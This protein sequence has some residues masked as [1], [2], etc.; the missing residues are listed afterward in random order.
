MKAAEELDEPMP[1][2]GL[3]AI[4]RFSIGEREVQLTAGDFRCLAAVV[5][6]GAE[7]PQGC[8]L[9]R[10][11]RDRFPDAPSEGDE[12]VA[13]YTAEQI[14]PPAVVVVRDREGAP[15]LVAREPDGSWSRHRITTFEQS[16]AT[17]TPGFMTKVAEGLLIVGGLLVDTLIVVAAAAAIAGLVYLVLHEQ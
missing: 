5:N 10:V 8:S 17:G 15:V 11:A 4:A 2:H 13:A 9:E 3:V 1:A 7:K 6:D 12:I 16:P 14:I